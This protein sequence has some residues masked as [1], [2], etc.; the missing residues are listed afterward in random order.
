MLDFRLDHAKSLTP[1]DSLL[2]H[3]TPIM[4]GM[5]ATVLQETTR[6]LGAGLSNGETS[7]LVH[8]ALA[9]LSLHHC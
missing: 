7:F 2:P 4:H 9:M 5:S 6:C 3:V 8:L 1:L